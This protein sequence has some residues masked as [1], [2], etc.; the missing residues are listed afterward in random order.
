MWRSVVSLAG[1]AAVSLCGCGSVDYDAVTRGTFSGKANL[2]WVA[3]NA[4]AL[5]G[6]GLFL[7]VPDPS[8]P[9][10][11]ERHPSNDP[12]QGSEIITPEAFFTDGGS[13]PRAVQ[14]APGFNAWGYGPAYVIHDWVFVA[15]KCMNYDETHAS[16]LA[17]NEMKKLKNLS[18]QGSVEIM[19]ETIKALVSDFGVA[20]GNSLSGPI[21]SNVTAGPVSYRLWEEDG[22]CAQFLPDDQATGAQTKSVGALASGGIVS[23]IQARMGGVSGLSQKSAAQGALRQGEVMQLSTGQVARVIAVYDVE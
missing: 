23:E 16:T 10:V 3:P 15:R 20:N 5:L 2:V 9:L 8:E 17:T 13:I 21:I 6:D 11:F 4:T 12:A 1:F 18:F 14:A 7:Y 19:A 22:E